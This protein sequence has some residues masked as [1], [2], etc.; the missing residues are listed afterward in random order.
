MAQ[1]RQRR[2]ASVAVWSR[3]PL[4]SGQENRRGLVKKTSASKV[5]KLYRVSHVALWPLASGLWP[6]APASGPWHLA[7]A[8]GQR[9]PASGTGH[10]YWKAAAAVA[11]LSH[12]PLLDLW[13][14]QMHQNAVWGSY[15]MPQ[16]G[17]QM[18]QDAL[19]RLLGGPKM[20]QNASKSQWG[21][22]RFAT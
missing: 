9:P 7:L 18:H 1:G 20:Q 17:L 5:Y 16:D 14:L 15:K 12:S 19:K 6:L 2:R 3:K 4:R 22:M 21:L 10:R 11:G 8:S 13:A